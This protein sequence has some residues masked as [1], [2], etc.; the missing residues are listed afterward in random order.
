VAELINNEVVTTITD[1]TIQLFQKVKNSLSVGR[2]KGN[3]HYKE[4]YWFIDVAPLHLITKAN[5]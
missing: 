4:S 2:L 5:L 1:T 3:A